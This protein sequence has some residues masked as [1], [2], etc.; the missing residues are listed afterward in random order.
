MSI[1]SIIIFFLLSS[2]H[3]LLSFLHK[4]VIV[5]SRNVDFGGRSLISDVF[6]FFADLL[7]TY[8]GILQVLC[9]QFF[10]LTIAKFNNCVGTE[11]Q[12]YLI[13]TFFCFSLDEDSLTEHKINF[14]VYI[15]EI[16]LLWIFNELIIWR[17]FSIS[18]ILAFMVNKDLWSWLSTNLY[19]LCC[20]SRTPKTFWDPSFLHT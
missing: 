5:H 1:H 6:K 3:L 16:V 2:L 20:W 15:R 8:S 19:L 11:P 12:G 14:R 4:T 17:V 7:R 18:G 10:S 9:Q 13:D